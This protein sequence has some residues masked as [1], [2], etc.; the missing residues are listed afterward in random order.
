MDPGGFHYPGRS[1]QQ[2]GPEYQRQEDS[3]N[4][5]LTVPGGGNA[6]RV[7]VRETDDGSGEFIL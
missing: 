5:L 6:V 1:V 7:G 2:G 4:G 3:R